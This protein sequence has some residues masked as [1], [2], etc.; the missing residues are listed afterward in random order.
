[1]EPVLVVVMVAANDDDVVAVA[2]EGTLLAP[3]SDNELGGTGVVLGVDP[4]VDD[5]DLVVRSSASSSSSSSMFS[6]SSS[7]STDPELCLSISLPLA[8]PLPEKSGVVA[9]SEMPLAAVEAEDEE[10]WSP[11]D[12]SELLFISRSS[13]LW[14]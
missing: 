7:S 14:W 12:K 3:I 10:G 6:S 4:D 1:M 2:E 13:I 11:E 9:A 5:T 8:L